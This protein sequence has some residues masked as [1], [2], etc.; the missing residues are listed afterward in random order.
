MEERGEGF[1]MFFSPK[2]PFFSEHN[3][4]TTLSPIIA[5]SVIFWQ[6]LQ[7]RTGQLRL[8]TH[9]K[10]ES[11]TTPLLLPIQYNSRATQSSTLT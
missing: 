11:F 7:K 3:A 6:T 5:L 9:I 10:H 1:G 4:S 2:L 8:V